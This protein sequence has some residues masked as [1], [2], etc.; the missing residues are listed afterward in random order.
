MWKLKQNLITK[1]ISLALS[2]DHVLWTHDKKHDCA[3]WQNSHSKV[4]LPKSDIELNLLDFN[5]PR[6]MTHWSNS[7]I[8]AGDKVWYLLFEISLSPRNI[9]SLPLR[10]VWVSVCRPQGPHGAIL[11]T[12][13]SWKH[14]ENKTVF[15]SFFCISICG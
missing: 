13:N 4:D 9:I 5:V 10:I 1:F 6:K 7:F 15:S 11:N 8:K 12:N 3:G 14:T 2:L